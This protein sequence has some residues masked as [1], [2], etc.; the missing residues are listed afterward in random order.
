MTPKVSVIVPVFNAG[1]RLCQCLDSLINQTLK[2]IEI[3]IVLDCPTDGSDKVAEHYASKDSRIK[4]I[5]NRENLNIGF[6]RN[7]G[8]KIA[9][10]EYVGFSDHDDYCEPQ[11]FEHLYRNATDRDADIVISDIGEDINGMKHTTGF[12]ENSDNFRESYLRSLINGSPFKRGT[13]SFDNCNS[14][15]NQIYRRTFLQENNVT[16]SDNRVVTYE[17]SLFLI[18]AYSLAKSVS[19]IPETLYY[20]VETGENEYHSYGYRSIAKVRAYLYE[21]IGFLESVNQDTTKKYAQEISNS[22]FQRIFTSLLNE[23]QFKGL[24]AFYRAMRQLRGDTELTSYI[25][26]SKPSIRL[27]FAKRLVLKYLNR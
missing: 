22:I 18:K 25:K 15:W 13:R 27:T 14:I 19:Y 10:G 1:E 6:S 16:F 2:E 24:C 12:P 11:M 8:L 20:H 4:L 3:I 21:M 17:D 7:E 9:Q 26:S 23:L 5:R